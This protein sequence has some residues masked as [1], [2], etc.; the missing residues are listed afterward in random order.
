M[1]L[2]LSFFEDRASSSRSSFPATIDRSDIRGSKP[3]DI[4]PSGAASDCYRGVRLSLSHRANEDYSFV[5]PPAAAGS[6]LEFWRSF[7]S[8][9]FAFCFFIL[10]EGCCVSSS[11]HSLPCSRFRLGSYSPDETQQFAAYRCDDLSLVFA[12]GCQSRVSLV[13]SVLRL[14]RNL[15]S[16]SPPKQ[17]AAVCATQ[18]RWQEGDD[19]SM[20]LRR[21]FVSNARCPFW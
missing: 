12:R 11:C 10:R 9:K 5:L 2:L 6:V 15:F 8:V 13:Q 3:R 7:S 21:R 14:P 20:P 17:S 19:N 16:R 4:G 18:P 1:G